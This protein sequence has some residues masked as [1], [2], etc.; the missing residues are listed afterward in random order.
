MKNQP[1]SSLHLDF[2]KDINKDNL[3][4]IILV[5][6]IIYLFITIAKNN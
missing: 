2:L 6:G 5:V 3:L 4:E 1:S